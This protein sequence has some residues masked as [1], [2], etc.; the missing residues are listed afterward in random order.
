M[1]LLLFR[2]WF[3][4]IWQA[5]FVLLAVIFHP[6]QQFAEFRQKAKSNI[7]AGRKRGF[8]DPE[9]AELPGSRPDLG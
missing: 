3:M 9:I 4:I 5:T 8:R 1:V 7:P 6:F 2:V